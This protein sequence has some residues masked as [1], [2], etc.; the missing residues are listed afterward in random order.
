MNKDIR[1]QQRFENLSK[2]LHRLHEALQGVAQEP[3]NHLY[4]IALIG[5]F[6]FTFELSWKTMKDYTENDSR[7][8]FWQSQRPEF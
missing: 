5:T 3:S 4:H 6:Q 8:D 2:A 7:I 1:W